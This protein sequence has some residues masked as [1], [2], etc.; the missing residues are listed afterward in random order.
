NGTWSGTGVTDNGDGTASFDPSGLSGSQTVTYSYTD[1]NGCTASDTASINVIACNTSIEAV[2]TVAIT[3]DVAPVGASLGDTVEYT[4]TVT[5][6]GNVTLDGV[7]IADTFEDANGNTLTFLTDPAFDAVNSDNVEG[8][9]EV[10]Q[11]AVYTATYVI[12]QDAVNAGGFSNS[13]EVTADDPD[14]NQISDISDDGDDTD[15]NTEDDPTVTTITPDPEL[16]VTKTTDGVI[17]S[18]GAAGLI[19]DTIDYTIT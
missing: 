7:G 4:I 17:T 5:N 3:N 6:T 2:K 13:V 14:D 12:G 16:T 8:I 15:G 19:D 9:L 1:G 18:A 11:V 10:G